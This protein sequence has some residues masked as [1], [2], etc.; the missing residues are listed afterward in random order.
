MSENHIE[1]LAR[2][3]RDLQP[4]VDAER[5]AKNNHGAT[6]AD[7]DLAGQSRAYTTPTDLKGMSKP[8]EKA[9]ASPSQQA[10]RS[11][12]EWLMQWAGTVVSGMPVEEVEKVL[13]DEAVA[14]EKGQPIRRSA[15]QEL[16]KKQKER[17]LGLAELKAEGWTI[18]SGAGRPP[19]EEIATWGAIELSLRSGFKVITRVQD[20]LHCDWTNH[21]AGSDLIAYREPK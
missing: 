18:W 9:C 6:T 15:F 7:F 11:S 20:A 4:K 5:A 8:D 13:V 14:Y 10:E 17:D 19:I 3:V 1:R 21:G 12:Y 2:K 16:R